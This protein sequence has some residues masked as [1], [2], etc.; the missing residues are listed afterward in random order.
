MNALSDEEYARMSKQASA[1]A[2]EHFNA[3][4]Y[5]EEIEHLYRLK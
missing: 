3:A 2:K 1:F 4:K 5:V